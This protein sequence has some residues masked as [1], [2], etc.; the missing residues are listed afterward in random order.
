MSKRKKFTEL[1]NMK[2]KIAYLVI[3][4]LMFLF[5]FKIENTIFSQDKNSKNMLN[6]HQGSCSII[7]CTVGDEVLYGYNYDGREEL[8]PFIQFGDHLD[9]H[10]DDIADFGKPIC[11]TGRMYE[12]GPTDLY[13][14]LNAD[15][16]ALAYNSLEGIPM[17]IDPLK[18]YYNCGGRFRIINCS[19]VQEVIDFYNQ[20]N[21]YD[22]S[23]NPTW[24]WQS[25][26]ADAYGD[27]ITVGL[28]EFGKVTI[29]EKKESPFLISMNLNLAYPDCCDGPCNDSILRTNIATEM[30]ETIV[31]K[32]SLTVN[33]FRDVLEAISCEATTHSLIFNPKTFDIYVYYR[34]DF[35][36]VFKFNLEEELNAL[37]PGEV[38]FYDLKEMYDNSNDI[39]FF[40]S[41][42][43]ISVFCFGLVVLIIKSKKD[44]IKS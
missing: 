15:G 5:S 38:N 6:S 13:A 25:H 12:T 7:T 42:V 44:V 36:K 30:L 10:D 35:S 40:G 20:Y 34:Q 19:S 16:L 4:S 2:K 39:K 23:T 27:A 43:I 1:V 31:E 26:I 8:E 14:R 18:E 33:D 28:N 22:L 9:F 17:Y 41:S 37:A 32:Q 21:Y 3:I 29:T 11:C 24:Y